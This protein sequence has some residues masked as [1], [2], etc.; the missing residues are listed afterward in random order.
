MAH[1]PPLGRQSAADIVAT[2]FVLHVRHLDGRVCQV[3]VS[4]EPVDEA[5]GVNSG[6]AA[7]GLALVHLEHRRVVAAC[8]GNGDL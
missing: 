3:V 8:D 5:A 6:V 2:V 7:E 4:L 1:V